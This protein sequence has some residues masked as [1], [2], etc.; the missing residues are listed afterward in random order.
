M[1]IIN[2]TYKWNGSLSRRSKTD[3]IVLHHAAAS[4]AADDIHR[5]HLNKGWAGIGYHFYVQKDGGIYT[6]RPID[7]LGA[8]TSGYND[9]SIGICFEGN[10]ETETMGEAQL[11]SGRQVLAYVRGLYPYARIAAHRDLNA[12]AC[13]GRN[14]PFEQ[15]MEGEET[16]A[17]SILKTRVGLEQQTI[18]F[19]MAYRY[20]DELIGKIADAVTAARM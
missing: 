6:G 19:L 18:D 2:K 14:F 17:V 3:Y 1:A 8:Q 7:T 5:M 10:F 15:M 12:T 4:G 16:D 20:G 9:K 11:A 13:P